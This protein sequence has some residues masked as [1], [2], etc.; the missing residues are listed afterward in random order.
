MPTVSLL[1]L[2]GRPRADARSLLLKRNNR[3][4]LTNP[5]YHFVV[6]FAEMGR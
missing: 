4:R 6:N 3:M 1:H 2:N 5:T